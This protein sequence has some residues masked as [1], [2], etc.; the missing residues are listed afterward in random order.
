MAKKV[1]R[2]ALILGLVLAGNFSRVSADAS[3]E[4]ITALKTQVQEL[5]KRIE[6][7]EQSQAKIKEDTAKQVETVKKAEPTVLTDKATSKLKLKGRAAFGFFNAENEAAS[8]SQGSFEVPDAKIQ[9]AFAPDEINTV[10]LR[11]SLNNG[12]TGISSTSPLADYFFLQ[13]KDFIPALKDSPFSL[14]TRLGKFKLGFGEETW[15]DNAIES[16]LVS[17]SAGATTVVDEG[18]ELAGKIKLEK[19]NL[20]PLGWV[21]SFT[22]GN[23]GVGAD[24]SQ[25]KAFMG[26]VYYTP[27]DPLYLSASYYDSGRLKTANAEGRVAGL[28]TIPTGATNWERHMWELDARYDFGKGKK[29]DNSPLFSDSKS[30]VRLSYGAFSD[31]AAAASE[32]SGNFGFVEG[33]YNL[34]KKVY[35]A[36]RVSF[37]DLDGDTTASLNSVTANKYQRYSLGGGYRLRENAILKLA[38]DWNKE[39][40]PGI[41]DMDNDLLSL[42]AALQF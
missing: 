22:D 16:V 31:H 35:T 5:L 33:I 29:W 9:F 32:R 20:K 28:V 25:A 2:I 27:I 19:F 42:V 17:N 36:G 21:L 24:N 1:F 23:A 34:N 15:S 13:S 3:N 7:L 12:V 11:L 38:Y 14:S 39:S 6:V 26:K 30:I 40:G 18:L 37:V 4:E 8:Y 10:V 41:S